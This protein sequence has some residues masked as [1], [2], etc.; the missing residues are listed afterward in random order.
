MQFTFDDIASP[1]LHYFISISL[2][3]EDV[4][5][6]IGLDYFDDFDAKSFADTDMMI[7]FDFADTGIIYH[8][9]YACSSSTYHSLYAHFH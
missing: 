2:M 4:F 6:L 5:V 1:S 9:Y 3:I 7:S 8:F